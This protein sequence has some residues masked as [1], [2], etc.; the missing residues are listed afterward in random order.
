MFCINNIVHRYVCST[1]VSFVERV[2]LATEGY[3][4]QAVVIKKKFLIIEIISAQ[5]KIHNNKF[6]NNSM[7]KIQWEMGSKETRKM[8]TTH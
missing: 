8:W 3:Y 2:C 6:P 5:Q 7:F 4:Y 1:M